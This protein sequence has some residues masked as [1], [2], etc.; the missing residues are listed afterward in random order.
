MRAAL[1]DQPASP[2]SR[3]LIQAFVLQDGKVERREIGKD[4][5]LPAKALWL[6]IVV[7][8]PVDRS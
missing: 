2:G 1:P 3:F 4:D 8:T 5:P 6:D 7:S